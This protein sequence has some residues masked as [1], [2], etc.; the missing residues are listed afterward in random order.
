MAELPYFDLL[1]SE[2]HGGGETAQLWQRLVHGVLFSAAQIG[3]G[4]RL[5]DAGCGFGGT[6][7]RSTLRTRRWTSPA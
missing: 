6:I 5:L 2:R 4:Q 7:S 3:D 1:I